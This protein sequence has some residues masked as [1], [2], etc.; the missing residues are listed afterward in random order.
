MTTP[1]HAYGSE[2]TT[3]DLNATG[4]TTLADP[5]SDA[6]LPAVYVPNGGSTADIQL[7]VTDGADTVVVDNPAAGEA[8]EHETDV[9]IDAGQSVQ[10]NVTTAEGTALSETAAACVARH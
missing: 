9:L 3:V 4:T 5:D 1:I 10:V 7:E 2:F 8:I 6:R